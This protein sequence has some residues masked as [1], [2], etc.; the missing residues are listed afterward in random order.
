MTKILYV[1]TKA[2]WGGGQKYVYDLAVAAK[3][4][5][6]EVMVAY[7]EEGPLS[8]RLSGADIRTTRL[9]A[10]ARDVKLG[11]DLRAYRA[12]RELYIKERP[13]VV[14]INSAKA[15]GLGA[16]AARMARVPK[17]IFTAHG[18]AFNESRPWYHRAIIWLLSGITVLLSHQT[19]CVSEAMRR[20]IRS[21]PFAAH[22][23]RTIYNGLTCPTLSSRAEAR[24]QLLPKHEA[25]YWIGMISELHPT[26]RVR[27][28]IDAFALLAPRYPEAILVVMGEGEE[29]GRLE[30]QIAKAGLAD[31]I[32]LLGFRQDAAACLPAFDLFVHTSRSESFGL[33]LLEAACASLPVVATRVGGVPEIVENGVSGLLVERENPLALATAI[34]S[35]MRNREK[36]FGLGRA[37]HES[38]AGF[39]TEKMVTATVAL[40]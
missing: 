32:L 26:K 7:G 9:P 4:A 34:E 31:R 30:V 20:D 1:I 28:A 8:E 35:L 36:A 17:I 14:H 25:T 39:S 23:L 6:H 5:G 11:S 33:V 38:A 19:I 40:Y 12:L 10:L 22:K 16:L 3:A 24:S 15:G 13:D 27:D 29:H 37:L 2:S 18:W 21:F